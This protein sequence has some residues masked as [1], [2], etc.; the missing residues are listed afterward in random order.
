MNA[1][2][3]FWSATVRNY[4]LLKK[5][6]RPSTMEVHCGL[7]RS[8]VVRTFSAIRRK[9]VQTRAMSQGESNVANMAN[10]QPTAW[11]PENLLGDVDATNTNH[12]SRRQNAKPAENEAAQGGSI[13]FGEVPTVAPEQRGFGAEVEAA[14]LEVF[15]GVNVAPRVLDS[16][17]RLC[18]GEEYVHVWPGEGVQRAGSFM[19]GLTAVAFPELENAQYG[20]LQHIEE[21]AEVIRKEFSQAMKDPGSMLVRGTRIWSKAARDEAVAYGP[22]WRTLVLQDRGIWE[23]SNIKI[24]PKTHKMLVD[25][26]APTLEVFFARQDAK[27]GIKSHT[28]NANFIQTT[29]LGIDVPEGECWIK[30]GD[31]TKEWRNGKIIICDTSFMHETENSSE[32]DRYVLIMRHWHPEVTVIERIANEFLFAA[33]DS[34]SSDGIAAAQ[35][36]A[37][38]K[39]KAMQSSMK[40]SKRT[41]KPSGGGFGPKK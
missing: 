4:S 1:T 33:L 41:K 36:D 25:L 31:H 11:D 24:F 3:P 17:E 28:D 14:F 18:R 26:D 7:V 13:A 32:K 16:F 30:V 2:T 38:R 27:T 29:H 6:K 5:R 10:G 40:K 15:S 9:C 23:E 20:W 39:I 21:N 8:S 34:G 37:T 22:N 12:F 19:E 35:K